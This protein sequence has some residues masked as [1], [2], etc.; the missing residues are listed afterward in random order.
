M[1]TS[2]FAVPVSAVSYVMETFLAKYVL[3]EQV[4]PRRWAGALLVIA[5]VLLISS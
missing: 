3:K 5:G 1:D 2:S 4:S